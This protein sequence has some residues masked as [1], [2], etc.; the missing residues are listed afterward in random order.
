[1][2]SA[3]IPASV[4]FGYARQSAAILGRDAELAVLSAHP[5]RPTLAGRL[6]SKASITL[7]TNVAMLSITSVA[8]QGKQALP[9]CLLGCVVQAGHR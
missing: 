2:L 1:M 7:S 5:H 4:E 6:A 8:G 9:A 3:R